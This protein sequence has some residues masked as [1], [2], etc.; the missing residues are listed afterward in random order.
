MSTL[1]EVVGIISLGNFE[2]PAYV[3]PSAGLSLAVNL[4]EMVQ[5]T[6]WNKAIPDFPRGPTDMTTN[7]SRMPLKQ[8]RAMTMEE[9]IRYSIKEPPGDE[10]ASQLIEVYLRQIHP[11]YPF[12]DPDELWKLQKARTPV[13]LSNSGALSTAQRYGVF[14]LYMV[15]AIAATLLRLTTKTEASVSPEVGVLALLRAQLIHANSPV[16]NAAFL[17]DCATA[18]GSC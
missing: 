5:A 17:H 15:F 2:A 3:G 12:L 1:N 9:L 7:E 13:A 11:R 16:I 8:V 10:L 14:K 4:G 6:V 18:H